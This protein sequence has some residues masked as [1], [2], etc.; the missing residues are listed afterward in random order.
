MQEPEKVYIDINPDIP[1]TEIE[2]LCVNCELNGVTRILPTKIPFFKE[3][4]VMAFE[5]LECGYR[6]SEVQPGQCLADQGIVMEV[7][8]VSSKDLNRRVVKSEYA[9]ISVPEC[10]LEIPKN[11]QKGKLTTIEGFLS[12]ARDQMEGC[13]NEGLY[14]Q[15][16][17]ESEKKIREVVEKINDVLNLK[18]LPIT[19]I[20]DDPA[21]NS[22]IENPFAP[23]TDQYCNVKY[24][25]RSKEMCEEMG[26]MLEV[27]Y[28]T[29]DEEKKEEIKTYYNKKNT[30]EV[31][32]TN[33]DIS[34]HLI[35][36]TKSIET[37]ENIK[38]EALSFQTN[39]YCCYK[40]G[41][42]YMCIC[43]IPFF[44]EIIICCFKCEFCGYKTTE[45]K[46]GGG[47]SDKAT[48]LTLK[49]RTHDDFNRDVFKSETCKLII[50]ELGFETDTGSMGSVYTTVE[51]LIDKII[52]N[53][54]DTPFYH[55]DSSEEQTLGKIITQLRTYLEE[56]T[57]F[58]VI[59]DDPLSNSFINPLG[60]N[61]ERLEKIEYERTF[62][63]NDELGINDMKVEN[64]GEDL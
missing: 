41:N 46:G 7:K 56:K 39:C 3:I 37:N 50:P 6:S 15:F 31:Y 53:L 16:G 11:T 14:A 10:G 61:D 36:F 21:G 54:D 18:F 2:S 13:L 29:N 27:T 17:E 55:G 32:K 12:T 5:C 30:F 33:N 48:K 22:F 60:L 34:A 57:E 23:S 38:E 59:L 42:A 40:D 24:Y 35:D 43:T 58:T 9:N 47:I 20:L 25:K 4:I 51:G 26:Y 8:V 52:R 44:K 64:Y 19:F 28:H 49:V 45:V 62:E 63:Q 1:I